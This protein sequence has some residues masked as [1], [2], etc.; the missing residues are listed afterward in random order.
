MSPRDRRF[1]PRPGDERFQ[2]AVI[3]VHVPDGRGV[4]VGKDDRMFTVPTEDR[5]VL[6][7]SEDRMATISRV[8]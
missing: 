8:N 1:R 2:P 7:A 3:V 4:I 5:G 6:V